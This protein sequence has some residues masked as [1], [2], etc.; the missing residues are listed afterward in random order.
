MI[1]T[2]VKEMYK[3]AHFRTDYLG[4]TETFIYNYLTNFTK[5]EPILFTTRT[6][7]LDLF[8]F[9][10]IYDDQKLTRYSWAWFWD[11]LYKKIFK[12][13]LYFECLIKKEIVKLLHGHFGMGGVRMLPVKKKTKIPLITTFYGYDMSDQ[14]LLEIWSPAYQELFKE[15]DLFLVE[16]NNMKKEVVNLGCP[17]EKIKIQHLGIEVNRFRFRERSLD[18]K[19][20]DIVILMCSSFIEKKGISY[21]IQAFSQIHRKYKN[22]HLRII[23][24]G[25]LRE[26]IENQIK[27]LGLTEKITLLGY[28]PHSKVIEEAENAH[29]FMHPSA[30]ASNGDSEGGAPTVLLDMQALG[31]PIVSTLHADIPEVVVNGKSGLLVPERDAN[32]LAEKLDYLIRSPEI[33]PEMGKAGREHVERNYNICHEVRKLEEIYDGLLGK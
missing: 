3:V 24:D 26:E 4:L 15:G 12:R 27:E 32:A 10:P 25:E 1:T 31:L 7:N 14:R 20:E 22:I 21:G 28:Q 29:I 2:D 6:R 11:R 5:Y 30:I 19:D 9:E 13:E 8:P 18:S 17:P 16:G 23:G 33:W